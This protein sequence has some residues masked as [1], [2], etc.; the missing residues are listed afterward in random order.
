MRC[1]VS[2]DNSLRERMY[3]AVCSFPAVVEAFQMMFPWLITLCQ[4]VLCQRG[5]NGSIS[6]KWH[7]ATCG[8]QEDK[9]KFNHWQ[10]MAE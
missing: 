8:N 5:K 9:Q 7:H 4:P 2:H 10:T 6:L 1:F 3:L